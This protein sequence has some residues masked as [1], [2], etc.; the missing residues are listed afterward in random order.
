MR[1]N[2]ITRIEVIDHRSIALSPGRV[3]VNNNLGDNVEFEVEFSRQDDQRTLKIFLQ[4]KK[5]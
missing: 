2:E 3:Y 1:A 4:D 5:D